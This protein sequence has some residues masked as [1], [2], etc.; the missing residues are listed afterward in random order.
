MLDM[1]MTPT[2]HPV[3]YLLALC[4]LCLAA[5][6]P[7]PRI[8][9]GQLRAID[10]TP[11]LS[12]PKV[13]WVTDRA[14]GVIEVNYPIE[15]IA[16]TDDDGSVAVANSVQAISVYGI[17]VTEL[18]ADHMA[19]TVSAFLKSA[20]PADIDNS[21]RGMMNWF[22]GRVG[23]PN[24]ERVRYTFGATQIVTR[25]GRQIA[26]ADGI[27]T[28][29]EI[30]LDVRVLIVETE[31]AYGIMFFVA[32]LQQLQ[33]YYPQLLDVAA[34]FQFYTLDEWQSLGASATPTAGVAIVCA[35]PDDDAGCA[36]HLLRHRNRYI[37]GRCPR[38]PRSLPVGCTGDVGRGFADLLA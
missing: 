25:A 1:M 9:D 38:L 30:A 31:T 11:D 34:Q 29:G 36:V 2:P 33:A 35:I 26:L 32:P 21:L 24:D 4:S 10:G 13:V 19:G 37:R 17:D 5:C 15:W 18:D 8:D 23:A 3:L 20:V 6:A 12:R 28:Q 14:T 7:S 22:K 27:G 16:R